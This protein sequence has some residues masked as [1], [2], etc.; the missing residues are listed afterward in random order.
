[1]YPSGI[2]V[3]AADGADAGLVPAALVALT[4]NVYAVPLVNP[5]TVHDVAPVVVHVLPP[6][7]AVTVYP[8]GTLSPGA[9]AGAVHDTVT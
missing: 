8:V 5:V 4:T 3:T 6:G 7:D 2:G 9:T 1:M